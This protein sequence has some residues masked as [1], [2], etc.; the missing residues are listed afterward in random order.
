MQMATY[1]ELQNIHF[2]YKAGEEI[3]KGINLKIQEGE[4]FGFLGPNGAGKTTTFNILVG[5]LK[6]TQGKAL[7]KNR[8]I[9]YEERDVY[10]EVG[11]MPAVPDTY[12]D[13]TVLEF[14]Q[15]FGR[16][17]E[18]P[19]SQI[20]K[21]CDELLERFHL[22]EKR[23]ALLKQLSTGQKQ[24]IYLIR[25]MLHDPPLLILDE[26]AS[27][28]DPGNRLHFWRIMEEESKRGKT[29]IISSHI[30]RELA[31]F[32]MSLGI[33]QAGKLIEQGRVKELLV[34]Y[35]NPATI[36][37]IKVIEKIDQALQVLNRY[38]DD[39]NSYRQVNPELLEI[40]Y[41]GSEEKVAN[42]VEMLVKSGARIT[43][44]EP[45]KKDIEKIY[46]EI[47]GEQIIVRN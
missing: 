11:Y 28:L 25:A 2:E 34:K 41:N 24:S 37:Q 47:I 44:F 6:P 38:S 36:Y 30:L 46:E 39:L 33:L 35:K 7:I 15:F 13:F 1:V 9:R 3:L 27:G 14:L 21:K 12:D 20:A 17:H 45:V 22:P 31:D 4:I 40:Q 32:C 5:L 23:N 10:Q 16:C 42:L 26:P 18:L 19:E 29:I 8:E 43:G